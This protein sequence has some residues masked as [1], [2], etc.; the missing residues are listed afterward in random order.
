VFLT[1]GAVHRSPR[2][3]TK[4]D[5]SWRALANEWRTALANDSRM[6]IRRLGSHY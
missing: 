2:P 6:A 5:W 3:S 1:A 4:R